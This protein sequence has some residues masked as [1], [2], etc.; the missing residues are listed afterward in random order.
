MNA[1]TNRAPSFFDEFFRDFTPALSP[2]FLVRPLHGDPLPTPAQIKVEVKETDGAYSVSAEIPGVSREDIHVGV[3]GNVV[4]LRAEIKQEDQQAGE[5]RK[6]L[7]N[8]RYYGMVS[9]SFQ[10]PQDVDASAAKA[11]YDNGVLTLSLPKMTS[12]RA[13]RLNVE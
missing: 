13:Q 12:K 9:R 10:L 1:I 8:E 4:T 5:N 11:R 2:G 3:D 6:V 7:R